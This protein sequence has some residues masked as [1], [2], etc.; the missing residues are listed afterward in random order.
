MYFLWVPISG[1]LDVV[2]IKNVM[3]DLPVMLKC[4]FAHGCRWY[5]YFYAG[6]ICRYEQGNREYAN[7]V[8]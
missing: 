7:Q 4:V 3:S 5:R 2:V 6:D 1:A 8:H